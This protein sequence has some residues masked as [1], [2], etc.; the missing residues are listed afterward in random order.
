MNEGDGTEAVPGHVHQHE[1]TF[2]PATLGATPSSADALETAP[3]SPVPPARISAWPMWALGFVLLVDQMDQ[4][5]VRGMITPL[6]HHFHVGDFAIGLLTSSFILVN[7]IITLPAGYLADRWH[8]TRTI[9]H[10]VLA[11]SGITA[12]GAAA[13]NFASLVGLRAALGFGQAVTEPSAASLIADYYPIEKRGLAFSIQQSMLFIGIGAGIGIGGFVSSRWGWRWGFL[14][15]G[16]PGIA[17]AIMS[18]RLREP[19]RGVADRMHLGV[20]EDDTLDADLSMPLFEHGFRRF[21]ADMW[22]GLKADLRTIMSITTMRY[23]LIGIAVLQF[24]VVGISTWL[25]QFYERQLHV[26]QGRAEGVVGSLI[27][28]GGIPG[29]LLG[30]R[31]ADYFNDKIRGARMA[32]PAYCIMIGTTLFAISF[33]HMP[34]AAVYVFQL[35]GLF[36]IVMSIPALRAGLTDAL[37]ANLRGAGFGAFNVVSVVLGAAS[38]PLVVSGLSQIFNDN[39]RTAFLIV[40]PPVYV[41]AFVLLRARDHLEADTAKIFEAIMRAMQE[42]QEREARDAEQQQQP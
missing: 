7:G 27:V 5:I 9:G 25:P 29:I 6:E 37:P 36:I 35:L 42:A 28:I 1:E 31:F 15:A 39:L 16:F 30:G 13:P 14:V 38:A 19:K 23:A 10:T 11:W 40:I 18:Y 22:D 3:M 26:H 24:T 41:G 17:I 34:T 12:L 2:E 20:T 8:R 32:L 21:L 33:I 4:Y